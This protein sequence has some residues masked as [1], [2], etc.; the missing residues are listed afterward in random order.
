METPHGIS[1]RTPPR[2]FHKGTPER[3]ASK[4]QQAVSIAA[5][6]M[7]LPRTRFKRSPTAA[8]D[9]TSRPS[10]IGARKPL[11]TSHAPSIHSSL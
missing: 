9:S 5:F 10:V 1:R 6:A 7:R 11:V 2:C 8:A 4:S 3:V